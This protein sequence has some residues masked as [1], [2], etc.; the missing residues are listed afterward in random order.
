[1]TIGVSKQIDGWLTVLT[2][3][4]Q[5]RVRIR[6]QGEYCSRHF[7]IELEKSQLTGKEP[8]PEQDSDCM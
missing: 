3:P 1:M 6:N 4:M 7:M 5:R 8:I 2:I